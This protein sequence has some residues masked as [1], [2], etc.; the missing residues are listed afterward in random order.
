[1]LKADK[2]KKVDQVVAE[3]RDAPVL[4]LVDFQGLSVADIGDLR[5]RLRTAEAAFR[6]VKNT[7]ALRAANEAGRQGVVGLLSGPTAFVY[8][9]GDAAAAAK[10]LQAFIREKRKGAVKGGVLQDR[11]INAAEVEQLAVLPG[12]DELLARVVGGLASPLYGLATVLSGPIRGLAVV[13]DRIREQKT[14]AA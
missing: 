7:L 10:I 5:R 13:L 6:V 3:M 11:S 8:C 2:I 14:V 12:R 4:Y 1:M 9:H